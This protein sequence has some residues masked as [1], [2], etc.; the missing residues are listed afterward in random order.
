[1]WQQKIGECP[2]GALP[3]DMLWRWWQ[4]KW[5]IKYLTFCCGE[6]LP[7]G[8]L[9]CLSED[10]EELGPPDDPQPLGI[11]LYYEDG[12]E[13]EADIYFE[14]CSEV[15]EILDNAIQW[16]EIHPRVI[17]Q[18]FKRLG[19]SHHFMPCTKAP[20]P[21]L[22]LSREQIDEIEQKKDDNCDLELV[23]FPT[24]H[25]EVGEWVHL[26]NKW[27]RSYVE[28][29]CGT[30]PPECKIKILWKESKPWKSVRTGLP[31]KV[32]AGWGLCWKRK[33]TDGI[34]HFAEKVRIAYYRFLL[35]V[36]WESLNGEKLR[37]QYLNEEGQ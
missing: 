23:R 12:A 14:K 6:P 26:V 27:M 20:F 37:S 3:H 24:I 18:Y 4:V 17:Q 22:I 5:S 2:S 15:Y 34:L 1:M 35:G 25:S 13:E 9:D 7:W 10:P 36:N 29:T 33:R 21:P 11:S 19:Y 32:L 16:E 8:S 31:A 30:P 28:L